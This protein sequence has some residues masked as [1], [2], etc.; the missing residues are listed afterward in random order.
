M[1]STNLT[2]EQLLNELTVRYNT[3]RKSKD[4]TVSVLGSLINAL[5]NKEKSLQRQLTIEEAF[6]VIRRELKEKM[7][8]I[9]SCLQAGRDV[10]LQAHEASLLKTYLPPEIQPSQALSYLQS[11]YE[12]FNEM[13]LKDKIMLAKTEYKPSTVSL[14]FGALTK[15][16]KGN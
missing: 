14:D 9:Q 8:E 1:Y 15:L 12:G 3:A 11:K 13:Q 6:E 7:E 5:K 4:F 16:M 10:Q 2:V